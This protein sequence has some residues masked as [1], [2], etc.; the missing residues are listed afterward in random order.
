M[1]G[2]NCWHVKVAATRY[3]APTAHRAVDNDNPTVLPFDSS[4]QLCRNRTR[5]TAANPGLGMFQNQA[6]QLDS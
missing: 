3:A 4:V 5:K 2:E 6:F 1:C